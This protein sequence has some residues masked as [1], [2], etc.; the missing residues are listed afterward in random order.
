M[1]KVGYPARLSECHDTPFDHVRYSD[2]SIISKIHDITIMLP[3][4][5]ESQRLKAV[6]AD[7]KE[8]NMGRPQT[9]G[10]ATTE[11]GGGTDDISVTATPIWARPKSQQ[12]R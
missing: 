8:S 12:E 10:I 11:A 1:L 9:L 4:L 2:L 3:P 7:A 5:R 6:R